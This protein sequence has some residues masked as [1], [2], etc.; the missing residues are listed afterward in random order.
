MYIDDLLIPTSDPSLLHETKNFLF[1]NFEM[2]EIGEISR[3]TRIEFFIIGHKEC[4]DCLGKYILT[5][6]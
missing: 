2:K 6:A 4:W 3:V 1:K 5:K